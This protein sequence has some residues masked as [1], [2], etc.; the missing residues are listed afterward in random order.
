MVYRRNR[1]LEARNRLRHAQQMAALEA[2]GGDG[3]FIGHTVQAHI[4][5][6][7]SHSAGGAGPLTQQGASQSLV[8]AAQSSQKVQSS[9]TAAAAIGV[10]SVKEAHAKGAAVQPQVGGEASVYLKQREMKH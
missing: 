9:S 4:A 8:Q 3:S 6:P 1:D 2:S 7:H 10:P 5:A